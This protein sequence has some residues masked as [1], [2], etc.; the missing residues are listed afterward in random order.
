[1]PTDCAKS[2]SCQTDSSA[3]NQ[4][5]AYITFGNGKKQILPL[6]ICGKDSPLKSS[7]DLGERCKFIS[8]FGYLAAFSNSGGSKLLRDV[9]NDSKLR[10]FDPL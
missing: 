10:T 3:K 5:L 1:M 6:L 9:E 4:F 8:E 2:L 7:Y